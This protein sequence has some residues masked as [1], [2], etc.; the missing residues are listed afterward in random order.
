M[1]K[2]TTRDEPTIE[3]AVF[4]ELALTSSYALLIS[5]GVQQP[6]TLLGQVVEGWIDLTASA[7]R[8]ALV[9]V[10]APSDLSENA[11]R[12][13]IA[14]YRHIL[15]ACLLIACACFMHTRQTWSRWA[16]RM[17]STVLAATAGADSRRCLVL[18]CYRRMIVG[19]FAV[20]LLMLF[21]EHQI[22]AVANY[23]FTAS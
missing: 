21:G 9:L 1:S 2:L 11:A 22:P 4:F 23:F 6:D 18:Y 12:E 13:G 14:T 8:V 19:F 3:E 10:P 7:V 16:E 20:V 15:S 17:T 5:M